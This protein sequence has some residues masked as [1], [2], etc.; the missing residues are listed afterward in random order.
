MYELNALFNILV[1]CVYVCACVF[2]CEWVLLKAGCEWY[3]LGRTKV[4][5]KQHHAHLLRQE[6]ERV[7]RAA[8][9]LQKCMCVRACIKD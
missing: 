2:S 1:W 6:M 7:H 5:L 8:T 9:I 3:R 4:F